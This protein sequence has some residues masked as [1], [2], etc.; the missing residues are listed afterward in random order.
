MTTC[1]P[2]ASAMADSAVTMEWPP[3]LFTL[4][5]V[6]VAVSRSPATIGPRRGEALV[7]VHDTREVDAGVGVGEQL[8]ERLLLHDDGEGGRRDDIAV[9]RGTCGLG[10]EVD[11]VR[12]E[13]G[14]GE[15]A[16]LLTTDE[17]GLGG[18]KGP[19][20]KPGFTGTPPVYAGPARALQVPA[21]A[22]QVPA[23][24]HVA[25]ISSATSRPTR[26]APSTCW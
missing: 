2:A 25:R 11:R 9:A 23:R 5:T 1:A 17:V 3:R 4:A 18:R 21:R 24:A 12:R 10:V 22:L 20:L 8:G 16:H 6:R 13:H 14:A 15:L 7:A 19:P 26:M